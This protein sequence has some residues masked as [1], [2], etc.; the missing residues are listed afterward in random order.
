MIENV[1]EMQNGFD[2]K[3]TEEI[4]KQLEKLGYA[5]IHGVHNAADYGIPQKRRRAFFL[6]R[7]DGK[8]PIPQPS[9]SEST[10]GLDFGIKNHV[11]VWDA[12]SDLPSLQQGEGSD[13]CNYLKKP[14]NEYQEQLRSDEEVVYNHIARKLQPK[15]NERIQH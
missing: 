13:P 7:R 2:A 1:A 15:Q 9:H 11:T 12:I 5:V 10:G 8:T 14:E 3:Y 4:E 6:V